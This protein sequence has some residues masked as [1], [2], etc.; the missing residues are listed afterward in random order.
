LFDS[1]INL[2]INEAPLPSQNRSKRRSLWSSGS[3]LE[4]IRERVRG[5]T[6]SNYP[7][8]W[9]IWLS[10]SLNSANNTTAAEWLRRKLSMEESCHQPFALIPSLCARSISHEETI[11]KM[12]VGSYHWPNEIITLT[13][14]KR[15]HNIIPDS[16]YSNVLVI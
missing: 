14:P 2:Q 4:S 7:P 8:Q 16:S 1:H 3:F 6:G 13:I 12:K 11:P 15:T 5:L 9:H 10:T